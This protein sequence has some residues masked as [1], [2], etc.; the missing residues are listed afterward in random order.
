[1]FPR[2][3]LLALF[4][5]FLGIW[6]LAWCGSAW[7][8]KELPAPS[9]FRVFEIDTRTDTLRLS[10]KNATG[11]S[12][13]SFAR[14]QQELASTGGQLLFAMNAG[15]FQS[16]PQHPP[17]G[18]LVI[19]GKQVHPINRRMG[20]KTNFYQ[21]PNGVFLL[22]GDGP[23]IV[24]TQD[25]SG[26][27]KH[28]HLAT[29]SGPL[30]VVNGAVNPALNRSVNAVVRNGV[31][32][33]GHQVYFVITEQPVT[34]REFAEYFLATLHCTDALYLDGNIS[35]ALSAN[36]APINA[37]SGFGPMIGVVRRLAPG[38]EIQAGD[39]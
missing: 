38:L 18:L 1:M 23:H 2:S 36:R 22:A 15:M 20:P 19:D 13:G 10:W 3:S 11:E 31:G 35:G 9:P 12:L 6:L 30:L 24:R 5:S 27:L 8:V 4:R 25:Y 14:W 29:Q 32:V 33:R 26:A 34:F 28:V 7:A 37:T 17:M 21:Q 16:G 39:L